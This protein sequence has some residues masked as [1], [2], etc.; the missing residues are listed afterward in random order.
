MN[1][2]GMKRN[3]S[4]IKCQD[5]S[6]INETLEFLEMKKLSGIMWCQPQEVKTKVSFHHKGLRT[7]SVVIQYC[8][9]WLPSIPYIYLRRTIIFDEEG[10]KHEKQRPEAVSLDIKKKYCCCCLRISTKDCLAFTRIWDKQTDRDK[11]RDRNR[12][13]RNETS[14]VLKMKLTEA[15]LRRMWVLLKFV[16]LSW[17]LMY[18]IHVSLLWASGIESRKLT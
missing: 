18:N 12:D 10:I 7:K 2:Q 13:R 1:F 17:L 16:S 6:C 14:C 4:G 8:F 5:I 3:D 11:D 15:S 9:I